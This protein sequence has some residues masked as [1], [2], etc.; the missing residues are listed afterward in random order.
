MRTPPSSHETR[1]AAEAD[2]RAAVHRWR[3][4][5]PARAVTIDNDER[6]LWS[7]QI[8]GVEQAL[9]G[10]SSALLDEVTDRLAQWHPIYDADETAALLTTLKVIAPKAGVVIP[11]GALKLTELPGGVLVLTLND[12]PVVDSEDPLHLLSQAVLRLRAAQARTR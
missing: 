9:Q 2:L 5:I 4:D 12:A 10:S 7:A 3:P 11:P 8:F 1:Y 6:G